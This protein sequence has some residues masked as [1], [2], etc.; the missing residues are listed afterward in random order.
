MLVFMFSLDLRGALKRQVSAKLSRMTR[1]NA[2][3][4]QVAASFSESGG[5]VASRFYDPASV[6]ATRALLDEMNAAPNRTMGQNFLVSGDVLDR[7]VATAGLSPDN[8]ILEIGPGLGS[9]SCRLLRASR[10]VVA[11]EKDPQL[12][13]LLKRHLA[14]PRFHLISGDALRVDWDELDL[15][16]E[17]VRVVANLPYSISKPVL[18]RLLEEWRAHFSSLT[19]LLQREVADRLVAAPAT[20]AYGPMALMTQLHSEAKRVFDVKPGSFWPS[21]SVTSS[22]VH[23]N[24]RQ[25]PRLHLND[26]RFFWLIVRAAFGQRRKQLGN[27]LRALTPDREMLNRTLQ[28]AQIDPMR[29]GETLSLEEFARLSND[30]PQPELLNRAALTQSEELTSAND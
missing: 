16:R 3:D 22:V 13:A 27:T 10:R 19:L 14:T 25:T 23:I 12:V 20:P 15:P 2:L 17:N 30:W 7:I 21:P 18:R 1:E 5:E 11:I 9:L 28:N 29:R 26:E 24:V 4:A 8:E 6:P